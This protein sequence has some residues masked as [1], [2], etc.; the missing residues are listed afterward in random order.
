[1][2]SGW[3]RTHTCGEL[4]ISHV[5]ETIVLNGW[6]DSRRDH[7]G[8]LFVDLRDRFGLTQVVFRPDSEKTLHQE[9]VSLRL[10][11]VIS[12]EGT[13]SK[14]PEESINP[15]RPTGEIEVVASKLEILNRSRTTPF[16]ITDKTDTDIN[17][18]LKYRYLD[19][20]RSS[21]QRTLIARSR[22]YQIVRNHL[23]SQN[24]IEVETPIL[25]RATPEGA[26]DYLVPSRVNPGKFYALPQ[27]P[28]LFKQLLMVSG[29]DRYFQIAKCFRDE[30]LRADRQPEFTQIDLEMS[31]VD[32]EDVYREVESL[33]AVILKEFKGVEISLPLRRISYSEAVSRFGLDKPDLRFGLE[34]IDISDLAKETDFGIFRSALENGGIVKA[35]AVPKGSPFT[36]KDLD[37]FGE[38]VKEYGAKGLAYLRYD[39]KGKPSGPV[40]KFVSPISEN[41]RKLSPESDLFLFVADQ[42]H[43]ANAALGNLRNILGSRL[44]LR[45]PS[46]I[47]LCWV[48]E[49]PMFEKDLTTGQWIAARHPFTALDDW[50]LLDPGADPGKV[51]ARAYDFV[52]NGCELGSGS[53]RIHRRDLQEKVFTFLGM[54]REEAQNRFGFLLNALDYG[55]PPHGGF[56]MGVDRFVQLLLGAEGI[57]EVIAFPKTASGACLMTEAPSTVSA[58]QLAELRIQRLSPPKAKEPVTGPKDRR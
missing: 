36:R 15:Q 51:R 33:I 17:V 37:S 27:S 35:I 46:R 16:E 49:F 23:T 20:R 55:A 18:R 50:S 42:P 2:K 44:G 52:F 4:C 13:V 12:L 43:I 26:R 19:L 7:G 54:D 29:L 8:V 56:A 40:S 9:A 53:I 45:D 32:E 31:F 1:M 30:D 34:L 47:E 24:F 28:Q 48:T 11:D 58:E 25:T 39:E 6:V 38:F 14:R 5:G 22:F 41:L 3:K 10:Q 21:M 57:R